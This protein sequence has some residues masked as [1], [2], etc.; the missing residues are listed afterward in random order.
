MAKNRRIFISALSWYE[1]PIDPM[2]SE[3]LLL[4]FILLSTIAGSLLCSLSEAVLLSLNP[5]K[6]EAWARERRWH[7]QGWKQLKKNVEVPISAILIVNTLCNTGGATLAG[8]IFSNIAQ[9]NGILIF[10][11]TTA[12]TL[13]I[14]YVS[15]IIP[16]TIGALFP[17]FFAPILLKPLQIGIFILT[18]L[19]RFSQ[20]L[21][22]LIRS[23]GK[24]QGASPTTSV[25]IEVIAEMARTHNAIASEQESII[26]NAIK[27]RATQL[28]EIMI[29]AQYITYFRLDRPVTENL[30]IGQ[31]A[32]HT[33]YPVSTDGD[34][35]NIHGYI[36]YKDLIGFRE[37]G[38]ALNL[39]AF[40]RP[41]LTLNE[42]DNLTDALKRLSARH[43]HIAIIKNNEGHVV[44]MI[45]LE[46]LIE[47]LV[48]DIDDEFDLS[49]KTIIPITENVWRV[50]GNLSIKGLGSVL[51]EEIPEDFQGQTLAQWLTER[52]PKDYYPGASYRLRNIQF[53]IQQAR[54]GKIYQVVIKRIP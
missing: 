38:D 45:T 24:H 8:L 44:G 29:P 5:L 11:F 10:W 43:H 52:L 37:H 3:I 28:R 2:G 36:N 6:L 46:D 21:S 53:N 9:E 7:A 34:P 27:M 25:D 22:T 23:L 51:Q 35:N 49:A 17:E 31:H 16:K 41:I 26:V 13:A 48:G 42:S 20:W 30:R 39:A 32:M 54:R 18:P 19:I 12:L 33:R 40:I 15:E 14:L 1:L 50:G 4:T 47:T